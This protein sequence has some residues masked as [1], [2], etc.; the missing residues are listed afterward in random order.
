MLQ[1]QPLFWIE[2]QLENEKINNA[3]AYRLLLLF[4]SEEEDSGENE[5]FMNFIYKEA[6][7]YLPGSNDEAEMNRLNE[8]LNRLSSFL[9]S[10]NEKREQVVIQPLASFLY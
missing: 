10:Q 6:Q 8:I 4:Y 9:E 2:S 5:E 3:D 1:L 7:I